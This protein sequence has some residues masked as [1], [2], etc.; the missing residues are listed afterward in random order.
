MRKDEQ[1]N[2]TNGNYLLQP[3]S[4][5]AILIRR[6]AKRLRLTRDDAVLLAAQLRLEIRQH[7][8]GIVR[9]RKRPSAA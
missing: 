6:F 4:A 3:N 7:E 9:D 8:L 1:M 2:T 5:S